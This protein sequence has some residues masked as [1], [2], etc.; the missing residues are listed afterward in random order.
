MT[1]AEIAGHNAR[2]LRLGAEPKKVSLND[3][4]LAL[5]PYGL[6][7]S[8]GRVGDFEGGRAAANLATLIAVTAALG[9]ILGRPV[10]LAELF[11]GKGDVQINPGYDVQ[12]PKLRAVLSGQAVGG[13]TKPRARPQMVS[14]FSALGQMLETMEPDLALQRVALTFRESDAR[15]CKSLGVG[16]DDGAAAMAK[17]WS[18]TFTTERDRRAGPDANAQRRGRISRQLKAELQRELNHGND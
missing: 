2:E 11:A 5:R 9:D 13:R 4:A 6:R 1:L 3:F 12:L 8:T 17:L 14:Q 18:K 10:T 7:W 15:I 16:L